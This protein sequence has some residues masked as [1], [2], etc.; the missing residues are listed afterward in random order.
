MTH[1]HCH[2]QPHASHK[3]RSSTISPGFTLT[4]AAVLVAGLALGAT[5]LAPTLGAMRTEA[6]LAG[7]RDNLRQMGSASAA[8]SAAN[9]GFLA[10][11]DWEAEPGNGG[12]GS[13][14]GR[15]F[16]TG[17]EIYLEPDDNLEAA[18]YQ[19]AA[20][21]RKATGRCGTLSADEK[22]LPM[23]TRLP[24]RRF[25]HIPLLDWMGAS[26]TDPLIA[27]PLDTNLQEFQRY[28]TSDQYHL[29]PGGNADFASDG[30]TNT[31][32]VRMWPYTSSYRT[33][34]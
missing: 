28:T 18:Q 8:Y 13:P 1:A 20:I 23:N 2:P 25:T 14:P 12:F 4:E 30:W 16:D 27:S 5:L 6:G 17:C 31:R 15:L 22:I 33:T 21:L 10:G 34:A 19:L 29:L 7:S 26:V 3:A 24:T 9:N 32:I 11:F